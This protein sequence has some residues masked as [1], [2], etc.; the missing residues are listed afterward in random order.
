MFSRRSFNGRHL[1]HDRHDLGTPVALLS[2]A[3]RPWLLK[4]DVALYFVAL[5]LSLL[6]SVISRG[7]GRKTGAGRPVKCL[8]IPGRASHSLASGF[9]D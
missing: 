1:R 6:Y 3:G 7:K 8:P 4:K 9:E 2:R 5:G